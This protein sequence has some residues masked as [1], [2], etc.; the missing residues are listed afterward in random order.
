M[1][2]QRENSV[3]GRKVR[4]LDAE[5]RREERRRSLRSTAL[6]LFAS[7]GYHNTAIEEL[8]QKAAVGT[9]GFYELYDSK[10]A[11]YLDL[12]E[13]LTAELFEAVTTSLNAIDAEQL[14]AETLIETFARHVV[15]DPRVLRVTF[16]EAAAISTT[17]ERARRRNRRNAA[18]LVETAWRRMG[19][20]L[21]DEFARHIALGL[22]GG[23]FEILLDWA[24]EHESIEEA[25]ITVLIARLTAFHDKIRA[26]LS[27]AG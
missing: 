26:G 4:G 24:H 10:E 16:G 11:C 22:I 8:C 20:Q 18:A 23:L 27:R 17:V 13:Q 3:A 12:F 6:E 9:K 14:D 5:Q 2:T 19:I 21:D 15:T 25:D 1:T 7:K